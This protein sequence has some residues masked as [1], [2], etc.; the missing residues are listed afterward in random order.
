MKKDTESLHEAILLLQEKRKKE[1]G[2]FKEQLRDTYES[3]KPINLIKSTVQEFSASPELKN[4]L[5]GSTLGI[6]MGFLA[7]KI[8]V[9]KS[10]SPF[11]RLMG[12]LI[13]FG[14]TNV[15]SKHSDTIIASGEQL[16]EFISE[17][18][19]ESTKEITQ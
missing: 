17:Y 14:V 8:V 16:I 10:H 5:V 4:N 7:K 6:G 13:Q 2:L 11:K 19:K 3:L 9:G 12:L 15:V 1:L 18:R